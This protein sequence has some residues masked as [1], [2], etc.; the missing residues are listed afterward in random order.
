MFCLTQAETFW[1]PPVKLVEAAPLE[2]RAIGVP[3]HRERSARLLEDYL[4]PVDLARASVAPVGVIF[5]VVGNQPAYVCLPTPASK[6]VADYA[7]AKHADSLLH[8][9]QRHT[10][11][12]VQ[13]TEEHIVVLYEEGVRRLD[14]ELR[15]VH[16]RTPTLAVGTRERWAQVREVSAE[17]CEVGKRRA[18]VG[19]VK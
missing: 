6:S 1:I 9:H 15:L 13:V 11:R 18:V 19:D 2:V 17:V 10:R 7:E 16:V 5:L 14:V 8:F 12:Q 3:I 4:P